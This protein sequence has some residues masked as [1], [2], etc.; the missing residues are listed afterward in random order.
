MPERTQDT[1][2]KRVAGEP[3]SLPGAF[4]PDEQQGLR[5]FWEVYQAHYEEVSDELRA[6]FSDHPEIGPL[7]QSMSAEQLAEQGRISQEN[8]RRAIV[9]GDWQPYLTRLREQ[10]STYA[11]AGLSF[12]TWFELV[13]AFRGYLTPHLVS[14]YA[15]Q[16]DRLLSTLDG[17]DRFVDLA[18]A[19]IGEEYVRSKQEVILKQQAAIRELSTPVLQVRQGLLL[20]PLVGLVD[21][22]RAQQLTESLLHAIRDLRARMAVIDITGVPIVDTQVAN[23]LV[24]TVDAARLMGAEVL[25]TG[26]S[27]EI[28]QTLVRLETDLAGRIRTLAT[29]QDGIEEGNRHLGYRLVRTEP[30]GEPNA[31]EEA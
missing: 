24:Q 11:R 16:T 20:L 6:G 25:V 3:T 14:T 29:L 19:A 9:D 27:A 5:D 17:M 18:M 21:T 8:L 28:A 23:H 22:N 13:G 7:L 1:G 30:G 4:T 15:D 2:S 26:I 12:S 31:H 10:G